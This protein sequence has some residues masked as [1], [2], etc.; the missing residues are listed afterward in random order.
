M[1]ATEIVGAFITLLKATTSEAAPVLDRHGHARTAVLQRERQLRDEL[2]EEV[3]KTKVG[4]VGEH[5]VFYLRMT[6]ECACEESESELLR[7]KLNDVIKVRLATAQCR[8]QLG[9]ETEWP[10]AEHGFEKG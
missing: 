1:R 5:D 7:V 8:V 6:E 2:S 3:R 4:F 10:C 9:T